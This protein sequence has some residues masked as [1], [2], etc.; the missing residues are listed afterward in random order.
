MLIRYSGIRG[1][2]STTLEPV[3]GR[4]TNRVQSC[5]PFYRKTGVPK[6]DDGVC[7]RRDGICGPMRN[8]GGRARLRKHAVMVSGNS[9][10]FPSLRQG[11]AHDRYAIRREVR[12][13][14]FV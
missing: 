1:F 6:G 13:E 7:G 10:A 5:L 9:V 12:L 11:N 2:S 14:S 3:A 4:L 8:L